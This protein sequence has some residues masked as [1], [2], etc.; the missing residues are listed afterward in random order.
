MSVH[1]FTSYEAN[2]TARKGMTRAYKTGLQQGVTAYTKI[3]RRILDLPPP[4]NAFIIHCTAGKDRTGILGALI[5]SLSGVEDEIIAEEYSLT[6]KGLGTWLETLVQA[7]IKQTK[8]DEASARRMTGAKKENM[9]A[10][11]K[12]LRTD[13]GGADGYLR[14][15]CGFTEKEIEKIKASLVVDE[16]PILG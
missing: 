10:A 14:D 12:M 9:A 1:T 7:V 6:E 2:S 13:F 4:G 5:L 15:H 3:F 11:L 8:T 16:K